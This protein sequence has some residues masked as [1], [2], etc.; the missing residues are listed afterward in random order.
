M[1]TQTFLESNKF[2][3]GQWLMHLIAALFLLVCLTAT[4]P[5]YAF[6]FPW[7]QGHD[8]TDWNDPPPPG[9]CPNGDCEND[10]CNTSSKGSPVYLATGHFIW[11]ETDIELKG[12]PY[13]A[14]T[15][16][17]NS[18]DPRTGLLGNGW[19]MGCEESILL[20]SRGGGNVVRREIVRRMSNGK[21]YIYDRESS[22]GR[23]FTKSGLFDRIVITGDGSNTIRLENRDGSYKVFP[24]LT[25]ASQTYGK[26]ISEVD[27]NGNAVNYSYD[28]QGR[29]TQKSDTNGRA[30]NYSYNTNGVVSTITDHTGRA[31]QYDY[32]VDGN[33]VAVTDPLGGVRQYAYESYQ[34]A[35]DGQIYQHLTRV[36]DETDVI[37]TEITYD[38]ERV[39]SYKEYENT[40]TYQYDTA[41]SR[42][43]KTDSQ[44]SRWIFTYN[45]TGQYTQIE[46][47]LNRTEIF[48]RDEDSLL[49][50]FVDASGTEY[51]YTYDQYSNSLTRGDARG[52]ITKAYDN[53]KPWPL[54]IT[55]RSGRTTVIGYDNFGNPLAVTD[56][57]GAVTTMMWSA[58][59][60]L[61]RITNALGNQTNFTYNL[62]GAPVSVSD[63]LNR[64]TQY[65]YDSVNNVTRMTNPE[66]EVMQYQYDVLDRVIA[67]TDG[68][69]DTT[70]Y[71][72]DAADR[73]TLITAP[74]NQ[75]V[76]N[77]Y[78]SFGRLIQ[79]TFYDGSTYSIQY[80][81][82]NLAKQITR[83]DNITIS[84]AYDL[85]KRLIQRT[86]GSEDDY[87]YT[88]NLR[89]QLV[90]ASNNN[91]TV[92]LAYDAFGRKVS[93]TVNGE[94]TTYQYNVENETIQMVSL[95]I[96]QNQQFDTRGLLSQ[97]AVNGS[98]Y[99]YTYDALAR[100][101]NLNRS[102]ATD[103][104]FQYDVA[105]QITQ[106]N[107]GAGLRGHQYQYDLA[108]RV[109]QWQGVGGETR[110]YTYDDTGRLATVQSAISP[111]T[112]NYDTM[113][114][115]QNLNAQFDAANRIT[116]NDNYV[117]LY[118][119]NGNRTQKTNKTTGEV[120]RYT[121]NGLDQL[122]R[123]KAYPSSD[124]ATTPTTD[125]SYAYGPMERRWSKQD[126]LI[127]NSTQFYWTKYNLVGETNN[128]VT[129][130]YIL[131]GLT[132]VAFVE[133]N[134]VYS[135]LKDHLGTAHQIVNE[136]NDTVWEGDYNSFGSLSNIAS[137]IDNN[138]RF[139][140]QYF[141]QESNLHYNYLRYYDPRLGAYLTSDPMGLKD[142]INTYLYTHNNSLNYVDSMG[143]AALN[144]ATGAGGGFVMGGPPGAVA[145][146]VVGVV[147]VGVTAW[148]INEA[149]SYNNE[150][151]S[152]AKDPE[153]AKAPGKPG[154][155]E[156]FEDPK[157]GEAWVPNPNPGK[158]ASSHGWKDKKGQ[159]WCPTGQ[160]GRAH[161]GPHWDVQDPKTGGNTN[162]RPGQ[163]I[164]NL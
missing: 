9:P 23:V 24:N 87:Q 83:P 57:S 123:Y 37:E 53:E 122:V 51:T 137:S 56:P 144:P 76:T 136:S 3:G 101:G 13:L 124:S 107:H 77:V 12:R 111:E 106:I 150:A 103:T 128:G 78:D 70:T 140:G 141:D 26:I 81:S 25:F 33:L 161:G 89:D 14:A 22:N 54:K 60:D 90:A 127:S 27:R 147:A 94:T 121:Y 113:G 85:A 109:S 40:F 152:D 100:L 42:V 44:G 148:G 130:R 19:N 158:G 68:N 48:D 2:N 162:V 117:Y 72:Y 92:T 10:P 133:N 149:I 104:I 15:R 108:S 50:R 32:D 163:N 66:G 114:N 151:P 5:V 39:A 110:D 134:K 6:H 82:D 49:T 84:V 80:R 96:T 1:D 97:L 154:A 116:E 69:G 115:R 155:E 45:Q 64:V 120:E 8:T 20:T 61:Q 73:I 88:Y 7:D 11:S 95:G 142:G 41:N 74:N 52:T 47:P 59:G 146:F 67:H 29:L 138:L 105:N 18:N 135:Y 145:G 4:T 46:K 157:G 126:N 71:A 21:R 65:G 112:F 102:T 34:G 132:P 129:R 131:E 16:T 35:G 62:Q 98:T 125:Y 43:T 159:V 118:D 119:V 38:E 91:G 86:V 55:S 93:E 36:T 164:N 28:A 160:G 31:W 153:G 99:R 79:R 143:M 58:E 156:G 139:S 30:L 63:P 75:T 17:Y